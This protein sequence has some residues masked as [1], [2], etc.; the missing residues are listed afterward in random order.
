MKYKNAKNLLPKELLQKVQ[1]YIQGDVIYIP[2]LKGEKMPWGAKNGA[3]KAIYTRNKDIF[4]LYVNGYSIEEIVSIYN[5][6]ESSIRK[7]IS[8]IKKETIENTNA[9]DLGG[10]TNE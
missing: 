3:R 2:K 6:S 1:E 10:L 4:N 8:K 7:I 9:L 5:L